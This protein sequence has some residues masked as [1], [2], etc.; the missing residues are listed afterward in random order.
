MPKIRIYGHHATAEVTVRMQPD[1]RAAAQRLAEREGVTLSEWIREA[2]RLR[3]DAA[4]RE[5]S[6]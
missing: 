4:R 5:D 3:L 6:R 1:V 2:V